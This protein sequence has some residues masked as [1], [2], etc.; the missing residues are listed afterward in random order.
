MRHRAA[1]RRQSRLKRRTGLRRSTR[2]MRRTPR[3]RLL[4]SPASEGQ[5]A[6]VAGHGCLVC[7]RSPVDPAH[8]VPRS[9]GGCEHPDCVVPLCRSCHR[10]YDR[11]ALDVLP[12]L[13]PEYRLE[14]A[15]PLCHVGR[16]ALLRRVTGARWRPVKVD[17]L[18]R[19]S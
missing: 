4:V 13:E 1:L 16:L 17:V 5:R 3:R 12:H 9:L 7:R 15:H 19:A 18:R 10:A 2:L 14:L 11:G 8:L 6:K